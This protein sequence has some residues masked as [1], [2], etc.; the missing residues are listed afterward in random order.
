MIYF[1]KSFIKEEKENKKIKGL[2][3]ISKPIVGE[4][5]KVFFSKKGSTYFFEGFCYSIKRKNYEKAD[6]CFKLINKIKSFFII[7]SF[8]FF[9]NLVFSF[10][11]ID[12]KKAKKKFRSAKVTFYKKNKIL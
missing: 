1:I 9:Y 6:T 2:F 11:K 12:F 10:E 5:L 7:F 3:S 4:V 8:S